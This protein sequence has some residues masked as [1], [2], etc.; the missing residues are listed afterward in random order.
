MHTSDGLLAV[1][2]DGEEE[3]RGE[4]YCG[5]CQLLALGAQLLTSSHRH[6]G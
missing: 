2:A 5:H 6:V 3:G 4:L 1:K